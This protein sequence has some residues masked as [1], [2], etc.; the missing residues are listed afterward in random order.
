[1][2]AVQTQASKPKQVHSQYF[3]LFTCRAGHWTR[4]ALHIRIEDTTVSRV[5]YFALVLSASSAFSQSLSFLARQR[6][7]A[8]FA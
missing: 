6:L 8:R 3:R 2:N 5:S 1:M 7:F 4:Q